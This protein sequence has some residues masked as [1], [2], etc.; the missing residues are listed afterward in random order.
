MIE[1]NSN[2]QIKMNKAQ[3]HAGFTLIEMMI[4]LAIFSVLIGVVFAVFRTT[5]RL[6]Q[7]GEIRIQLYRE[8]KRAIDSISKELQESNKDKVTI[9]D[10]T[11]EGGSDIIIFQVPIGLDANLDI[12]WGADGTA[13]DYIRYYLSSDNKVY[14]RVCNNQNCDDI[15]RSTQIKANYITDLQFPN[16]P[17][18]FP[19]SVGYLEIKVWA[20]KHYTLPYRPEPVKSR[21]TSKVYLRN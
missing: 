18:Q 17:A 6:R 5:H 12:Q 8:C 1:P 3:P 9:D 11:G 20:E 10:N 7:V 21:L 15:I 2:F 16:Y 14:R 4:V 19:N 13:D